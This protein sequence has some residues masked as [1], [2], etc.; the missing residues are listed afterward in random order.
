MGILIAPPVVDTTL[1]PPSWWMLL[2]E[3]Q[4]RIVLGRLRTLGPEA[5]GVDTT[6]WPR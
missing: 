5:T 4:R 6:V 2:T 3:N 1:P